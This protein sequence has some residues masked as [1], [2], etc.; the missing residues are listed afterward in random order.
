MVGR[1]GKGTEETLKNYIKD[2]RLRKTFELVFDE[3]TIL[4]VHALAKKGIFN[5]LE[6]PISSGKEAVVFRAVDVSGNY[7]AI[8]IYKIETSGFRHMM[9]YLKGDP[10]F[11]NIKNE[12][13]N[14]VHAW[15][16]KEFANL[17]L[18]TSVGARVPMPYA[19]Y[20]NVLAMEF[21]GKEGVPSNTL[22]ETKMDDYSWAYEALVENIAKLLYK[23][24]LVF[25]DLSEYNILVNAEKENAPEIVLIDIGQAVLTSHPKAEE[26][27]MRDMRNVANYFTRIGVKKSADELVE[28]VKAKKSA[29]LK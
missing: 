14:I 8:K 23:A 19:Y 15:T 13:R 21:I 24:E 10:R 27:F 4:A 18:A 26:F 17:R 29:V 28:D 7:K 25:A 11:K 5:V 2:E 12:K 6:F 9:D 3:S 16:K 20:E 1:M 22:R